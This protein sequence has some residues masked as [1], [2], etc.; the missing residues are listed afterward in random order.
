MLHYCNSGWWLKTK[1][2]CAHFPLDHCGLGAPFW[3]NSRIVPTAVAVCGLFGWLC[4]PS[5]ISWQVLFSIMHSELP[6]VRLIVSHHLQILCLKPDQE[7][8]N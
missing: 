1:P 7:L 6:L 2:P 3:D 5:G 4:Y 8:V